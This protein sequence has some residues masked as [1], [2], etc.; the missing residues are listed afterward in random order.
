MRSPRNSRDPSWKQKELRDLFR[1]RDA[2]A[3]E[4]RTSGP[5]LQTYLNVQARFLPYSV[6]NVL[7]I[8]AQMPKAT[9]LLRYRS[10][11]AAGAQVNRGE[12]AIS[13][14]EARGVYP[15]AETAEEYRVSKVF[16]LGQT[17]GAAPEDP[18]V[19][20]DRL[21]L[22]RALVSDPPCTL[23]IVEDNEGY[24]AIYEPDEQVIYLQESVSA[25]F[26]LLTRELAHAHLDPGEGFYSREAHEDAAWCVS[27][28]LCAKYGQDTNRYRFQTAPQRFASMSTREFREE[29]EQIRFA[30]REISMDIDR[31]LRPVKQQN[32][33]AR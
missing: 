32:R 13:L 31:S 28:L 2:T 8:T 25:P 22:L 9:M 10:W 4:I 12:K 21:K 27:Y 30:A 15:R 24:D 7:L 29:L 17:T 14:L 3:D 20:V 26:G 5:R 19:P 23:R 16:D 33:S 6:N 1:L 11:Q 18:A